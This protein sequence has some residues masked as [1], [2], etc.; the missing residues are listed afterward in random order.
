MQ[1]NFQGSGDI[2]TLMATT[3]GQSV[4]NLRLQLH[5]DLLSGKPVDNCLRSSSAMT[6]WLAAFYMGSDSNQRVVRRTSFLRSLHF[7]KPCSKP[8]GI[9]LNPSHTYQSRVLTVNASKWEPASR[10]VSPQVVI[11]NFG[12]ARVTTYLQGRCPTR[13]AAPSGDPGKELA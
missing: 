7:L 6:R 9:L 11:I 5:T 12:L 13:P 3:F 2:A 10:V 4:I 1:P 8:G